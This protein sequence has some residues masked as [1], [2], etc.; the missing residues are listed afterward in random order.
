MRVCL[1]VLNP[2]DIRASV[3]SILRLRGVSQAWFSSF[4]EREV[5]GQINDFIAATDFDAY[6]VIADDCV[7]SQDALGAV[8]AAFADGC[9]PVTGWTTLDSESAF[10]NVTCEPLIGDEPHAGAYEWMLAKDLEREG[11]P[12]ECFFMGFAL[13]LMSRELWQR[14]PF[15][16]YGSR[17][18][19]SDFHL[20][21]RLRDAGVQMTVAP[22]GRVEHLKERWNESDND[23]A[24]RL[25][26]DRPAQVTVIEA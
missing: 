6:A 19:A 4:T 17:G 11:L 14:F 16:C 13:T 26:F 18:F 20:S 3:E 15:D 21:R 1:L 23:P 2:R 24:K 12:L 22:G 25:R 7:C 8:L 9:D 10:A 5:A